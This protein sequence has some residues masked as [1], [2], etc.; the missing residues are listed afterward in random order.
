VD[1]VTG[2]RGSD[3]RPAL[4]VYTAITIILGIG[5]FAIAA[6]TVPLDPRI[7]LTSAGGREGI[8]LGLVFWVFAGLLGGMRVQRLQ[9]HG[10]L[11]FHIPFI[12]AATALGGPVA[13]AVVAMIS[14]IE[15]RELREIPW[16]GLVA[17]HVALAVAAL[18]GG[19]VLT[20][21]N[22]WLATLTFVQPQATQLI[23]IV[24]ASF[25]LTAVATGLASGTV[26]LRDHLSA[27]EAVWLF[28]HAYRRTAAVEVVLGWLLTVTYASIGWWAAGIC[29]M[30]VLVI[31]QSHDDH[32]MA[33]HDAM[34]GLLNRA[35]FA[36]PMADAIVAATR[37]GRRA[38]L[39]AI[40]LDG[41]KSINDIHGHGVGDEVIRT[42]GERLR[43]TIRLTDAAVRLGGDEF[44]VLL[45]EVPDVATAQLVAERI[46]ERLCEPIDLD[47]RVVMVGA[48]IGVQMVEPSDRPPTMQRVHQ[49]AD[50]LMYEAKQSGGGVRFSR[51]R[52]ERGTPD[53]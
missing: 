44:G 38:A 15:G 12:V 29:A 17:N 41:F 35:G 5:A 45:A 33:R 43:S 37:Q 24:V 6:Q 2:R 48:S 1:E 36:A 8:L 22:G 28:V 25:A 50:A 3:R 26:I 51:S 16:Y 23:A 9:D 30:L 49:L 46:H 42:V 21:L 13:G 18:A 34:T 14:T 10:V 31:W 40:D 27:R 20:W 52:E 39:L 11:T 32:E 7:S 53:R 4:L 47:D 19:L